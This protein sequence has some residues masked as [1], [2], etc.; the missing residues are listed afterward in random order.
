[1]KKNFILF[2]LAFILLNNITSNAQSSGM[3]IREN[4][5]VN[6]KKYVPKGNYSGITRISDNTYAVVSDEESHDGFYKFNI[7]LNPSTGEIVS[8]E[9]V[10]YYH[11]ETVGRDAECIAYNPQRKTLYIGGERNNSI[12]EF[13]L[14]GKATGVRSGNL[15]PD[16]RSNMG[17]E[18][19][20]YDPNTK[21]LWTM[22]ESTF[23]SDNEGNFS[24]ITN[25]VA[26]MLR[27][28][29]YDT[30]FNK[31]REYA[32]KADT[33]ENMK[34][35]A[36]YAIGVSDIE[37]LDDGRLLIMEREAYV[38]KIKYGAWTKTK[39]YLVNPN[40]GYEVKSGKP[41]TTESQFLP[42]TLIWSCSTTLSFNGLNW[43]NY[44]G[45][46]RGPKLEDGGQTIILISDSQNRYKG[47]LQDW[48]KTIVIN[49]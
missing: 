41:L 49:E 36:V 20:S 23:K 44:E 42:K 2:S 12:V 25:G 10:G 7:N 15:M 39:L 37:C 16:A 8:V 27:L 22:S 34:D 13:T 28:T 47:V 45:I 46:C 19:L 29:A 30:D 1:M 26:N 33:P 24:Q 35:G 9:N 32:Y 4:R 40:Q 3:T 21:L 17:M 31:I 14:E 5:A 43:A 11:S 38:P 18:S 6:L 48:M